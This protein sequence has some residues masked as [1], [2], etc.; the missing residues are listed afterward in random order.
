MKRGL[1]PEDPQDKSDKKA[2]SAPGDMLERK[3]EGNVK[4]GAMSRCKLEREELTNNA[5]A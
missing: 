2:L 5:K 4:G 3:K 1:T